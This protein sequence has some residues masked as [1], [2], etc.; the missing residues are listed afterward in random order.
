MAPSPV[1]MP[2]SQPYQPQPQYQQSMPMMASMPQAGLLAT[3]PDPSPFTQVCVCVCLSVCVNMCEC[4]S[5]CVCLSVCVCVCLYAYILLFQ[6]YKEF[7][8]K[9]SNS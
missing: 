2:S 8:T 5:L 4:V 7:A 6:P 3:P 1:G 9:Y